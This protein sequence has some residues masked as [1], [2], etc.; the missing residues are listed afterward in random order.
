LRV[1]FC[2]ALMMSRAAFPLLGDRFGHFL[3]IRRI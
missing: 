1:V 2:A 3:A